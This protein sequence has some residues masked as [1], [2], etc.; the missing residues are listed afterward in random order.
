MHILIYTHATLPVVNYGGTERVIWDLVYALYQAQHRITLLAG[1]GTHCEWA[2]VIEYNPDLPLD[3]QIP[4][5][6]DVVH[7]H[8]Q[9][10]AISKPY[11]ITQHGNAHGP[12]DANTI[13]VS[14][15][16]AKNH[17]AEAYVYNG[18]NWD[19]YLKPDLNC[20]RER[21]HFLGK[22]AWR[23]K[24]V[25]GA[26]DITRKAQQSLDV[27]GGHRLNFKM[28]FRFTLDRHVRFMGM[29]DDVTKSKVMTQ[30]KG[31]VFPVTWHE[32]FGLAITE[33][34]F[35]GCP[36]FGTPYGSLPE[37]VPNNI[38]VL[39]V[40]ENELVDAVK[41]SEQLSRRK[42]HEY[43]RDRFNAD[44]MAKAYL[45]QYEKV[46]NGQVLNQNMGKVIDSFKKLSYIR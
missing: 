12:I 28:G 32:P 15:Q 9:F 38:G 16:H 39:S 19:N 37:L 25:Q 11:V 10:E 3:N 6:I 4:D 8:S 17:G 31:L 35:F 27:L 41:N 2:R 13:F 30:S 18:L 5:D 46:L 22:A 24:N 29:V 34:L 40:N 43:A 45:V 1:K 20:S 26:I 33:S 14:S 42:C 21:F 7:F 44:V 36:V 23:V